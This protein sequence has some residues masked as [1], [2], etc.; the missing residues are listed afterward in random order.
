MIGDWPVTGTRVDSKTY[1]DAETDIF[2]LEKT[3]EKEEAGWSP[4]RTV[5]QFVVESGERLG[6]RTYLVVPPLI[7]M[8]FFML[9]DD[10]RLWDRLG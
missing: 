6:V 3:F 1:S 5:D 9:L 7:C 2:E 10:S 4:V 8:P